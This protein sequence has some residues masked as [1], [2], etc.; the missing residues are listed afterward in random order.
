MAELQNPRYGWKP[1]APD[2]RDVLYQAP[3]PILR[4]LPPSV[5]LRPTMPPIWDQSALGS[6]TANATGAQVW[7]LD[8]TLP[9]EP[10]RLFIYY[11]TRIL[12]GTVRQ[13]SGASI[14]NSIKSV[15]RWGYTP[16]RLF[17]YDIKKFTRKPTNNAYKTAKLE[18]VTQYARV[19]RNP[20]QIKARLADGYTI[21][22]GFTVYESFEGMTTNGLLAMPGKKER[23]LG[24]HA[25][26][27]VGYDDTKGLYIIRNSYGVGWGDN[28]Y[29]YMPYEYLH[30]EHLADDFWT[31]TSVP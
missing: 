5:D 17:P 30:N 13:D 15:V 2:H 6:C 9:E 31:I 28:G 23:P 21:N 7:H 10:S 8:K 22:F 27:A 18:R 1:D 20:A 4:A 29:F 11:N 14:R 3:A 26:L 25:V 19:P 24:G 12:E 16:E